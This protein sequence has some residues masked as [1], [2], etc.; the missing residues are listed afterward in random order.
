MKRKEIEMEKL[1][2]EKS[3]ALKSGKAA[4]KC[5]RECVCECPCVF[6]CVFIERGRGGGGGINPKSMIIL[7]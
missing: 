5:A 4:Y 6:V 1:K 3:V 7:S 2:M